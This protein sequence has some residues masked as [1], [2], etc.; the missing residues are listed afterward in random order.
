MNV[1]VKGAVNCAGLENNFIKMRFFNSEVIV[2]SKD[3]ASRHCNLSVVSIFHLNEENIQKL[4]INPISIIHFKQGENEYETII[5]NS[6]IL[7]DM[8]QEFDIE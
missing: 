1:F 4:R 5:K 2:L 3:E 7:M 6:N 8:L